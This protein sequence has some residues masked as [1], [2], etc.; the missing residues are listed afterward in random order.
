MPEE[1]RKKA[2]KELARLAAMPS[3]SPEA[4]VIRTYLDWLIDLPWYQA[5]EDNMDIEAAGKVAGRATLR[6]AQGQGAHPGAHG[7]SQAGRRPR[8][9][10]RSC[11][12]SAPRAPARPRWASP[13]PTRWGASSCASA[14]AASATRPRFAGTGAPTSARC[15]AASS[16]PCARRHDQPGLHA[17]RDRQDRD[18]LP[19]RP[20]VGLAG[21]AGPGAERAFSDHYLEVQLRPVQGDVHHH[22]QHAGSDSGRHC[23]TAWRSSYFPGYTEEE[24]LQIAQQ[25]LI[26]RQL[27]ENGL[28]PAQMR[29]SDSRAARDRPRIHLRSR[30]AQ[31]GARDRE[32]LPQSGAAPGRG[33][34]LHR[35]GD[36]GLAAEVSRPA[37]VLLRP[38]RGDP[39]KSAWLPASPGRRRAAI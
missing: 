19:R 7:R 4:T 35:A 6:P 3:A 28:R 2:D 22:R 30:R 14:W 31:P 16:R 8:C 27:D 37:A 34:A 13:S 17:G 33:Q 11:A 15:R 24:K 21:G 1:V 36:A 12:S 20:V 32:H 38:G 29:F 9:G 5:T 25:F 26:P 39:T 23:A 18:R 10:A